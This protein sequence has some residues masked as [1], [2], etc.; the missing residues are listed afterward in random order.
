MSTTRPR[1]TRYMGRRSVH[2]LAVLPDLTP[3]PDLIQPR[4][5]GAAMGVFCVLCGKEQSRTVCR[6]CDGAQNA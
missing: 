6:S 4:P 1:P 3:F 5:T 2:G